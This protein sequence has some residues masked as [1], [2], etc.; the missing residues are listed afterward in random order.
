MEKYIGI[1]HGSMSMEEYVE[2]YMVA[3]GN[4]HSPPCSAC[5]RSWAGVRRRCCELQVSGLT[6]GS[7]DIF[8]NCHL[9]VLACDYL[10][11]YRP[12]PMYNPDTWRI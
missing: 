6:G 2:E 11:I 8:S 3:H 12:S 5:R 1:V 7:E 10:A 4:T 9:I